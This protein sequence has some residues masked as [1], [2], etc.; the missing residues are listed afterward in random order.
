MEI[1]ILGDRPHPWINADGQFVHPNAPAGG[2]GPGPSARP[3]RVGGCA[4]HCRDVPH[5][6]APASLH[7]APDEHRPTFGRSPQRPKR[8][9]S[10]GAT[11]LSLEALL[12]RWAEALENVEFGSPQLKHKYD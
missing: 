10:R 3:G 8:P 6:Q 7:W 4:E 5:P 9:A 2:C 1:S 12:Q 11:N